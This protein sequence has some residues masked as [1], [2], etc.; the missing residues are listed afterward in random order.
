MATQEQF[1]ENCGAENLATA[2]FCQYCAAPLP[3]QYST[4][5]LPEETLLSGRYKLETR[6]GQG[7]MGAVY[8]ASD[9]R[10]NNRPI[11]IKEMGRAGLSP[12]RLQEAEEAFEHEAQLLAD[13]LHPN[14]PRIYDHFTEGERSYLVMDFIEG[15]TLEDYVEL[16]NGQPLPMEKVLDWG[17]QI[18]DVLGY[19]HTHQPPIIFRDLKPS[20]V[21][22]SE[23]GHVYLIDFGI[24]RVFKPGQSHD[25]VAL[26]SPGF[27]APEQ[28]GKA[29]STPR[30]DIYSL[31]ALL[32]C[33]LTGIDPSEQPFFFRP[34]SELNP[35][36]SLDLAALLQRMLDMDADRRPAS[37]QEVVKMLRLAEQ[38]R[39]NG[40]LNLGLTSSMSTNLNTTGPISVVPSVAPAPV[41]K[42]NQTSR[43]LQDA[44][45]LYSQRR[46]GD[47]L[48]V[49]EQVIQTDRTN[50][51]A[52]QGKGLT[53]ALR[54]R[55]QE[56]LNSFD[57][58]LR[59]DPL[60]I[61]SLNGKGTA[62]NM[63]H[64]NQEALNVFDRAVQQ[65]PDN[66]VSWN[67]KGAVLSALGRPEEALNSFDL[68]LHF[69]A[70]MAQAWSNKGLV[71]RQQKQYTD[72]LR[73]F[74]KA[75]SLEPNSISYWNGKGLV[76]YEMGKLR[77]AFLA[78]Q[79]ALNR[80]QNYAPALYG[81]GNVYYA[82]QKFRSALDYFE[83][84]IN[85]D[86]NFVKAWDK[87]GLVLGDMGRFN[88][89]LESY[90]RALAIDPRF[91]PAWNGKGSV[92]HQ[93][94]RYY[95]ALSAYEQAIRL[96]RN[97]PLAWN[98][99]GNAY[100]QMNNY[101]KALESYE[102]ALTLNPRM[103]SALHNKSLVL[104]QM[105]RYD[106]ALKAA[107]DAI[108][109]KPDDPDNWQR[110][111]EALKKLRRGRDARTAEAEVTRLRAKAN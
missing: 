35:A 104:R 88:E 60:L 33:L 13:L 45:R 81:I 21:M 84:A 107:E 52:W 40:T 11:A 87:R 8:K 16:A 82:Q 28:Y 4:G 105:R 72:A 58:A 95:E 65:E 109:L 90:N 93:L 100:Y 23:S 24:A 1:C 70:S 77:D 39:L 41:S 27:A 25:T 85:C 37:T 83:K 7:G 47:A 99:I 10:F 64:R 73:A 36:V 66:A 98:G 106:E 57:Q 2:R 22:I 3:F 34:A 15:R 20:N 59:L 9:S 55:H 108:Q 91:A 94:Q 42:A 69:D 32:H 19:L 74:E 38:H 43:L 71:L 103:V 17:I 68:A 48:A 89:A 49:Y 63:L 78:Y 76:L 14:L 101:Q 67:G 54:G 75:L 30:S 80:D 6:I 5:T 86:R 18:C 110:K 96:N 12:T 46:L 26:G 29:Q 79:E 102:Q 92:L 44:Y 56:A 62:L 31:G 111:V 50:A 61:T 97:A 53:Q 51:H